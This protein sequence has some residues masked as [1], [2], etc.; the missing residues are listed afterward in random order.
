M[1][2]HRIN[3][4]LFVTDETAVSLVDIIPVFHRWIQTQAVEGLLIDVADYK[5]VE[6]GPGILIIGHEGDYA[7]DEENSRPGLLYTRK[8]EWP[9]ADFKDRLRLV[10]R[11]AVQASQVLADEES[12]DIAFRTDQLALTFPD[13]LNTPNSPETF[14]TLKDDIAAVLAEIYGSD[15]ITLAVTSD[16]L[17]RPFAVQATITNAPSLAEL[18]EKQVEFAA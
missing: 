16:D 9:T 7:L 4:K 2:P 18:A 8:R 13:R 14:A 11:L 12:L 10:V 3:A 17:R 15:E 5:H 1:I 6:D